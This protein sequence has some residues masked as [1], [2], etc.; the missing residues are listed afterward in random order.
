MENNFACIDGYDGMY[1]INENGLIWS[2]ASSKFKINILGKRGYYTVDL[3][4]NNKRKNFKIHRL[5]A[6]YFIPNT[7]NKPF[8][9]HKNGIKTDNR[10]ENLEWCTQFENNTHSRLTKLNND[11]GESH[12]NAKLIEKDV[13]FIRESELSDNELSK[14]LPCTRRNIND[15]RNYKIWKHVK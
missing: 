13:L 2:M 11:M 3:W 1:L 4:K 8:I 12:H 7:E 5:I 6:E 15:I 9:N 10:I 14:I